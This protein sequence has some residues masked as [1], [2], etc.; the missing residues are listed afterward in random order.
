MKTKIKDWFDVMFLKESRTS[1]VDDDLSQTRGGSQCAHW[2]TLSFCSR[3]R[4]NR[5]FCESNSLCLRE[6]FVCV[7]RFELIFFSIFVFHFCCV[8]RFA[9]FTTLS[10]LGAVYVCMLAYLNLVI[11]CARA[12]NR[13]WEMSCEWCQRF[14]TG[15]WEIILPTLVE[16]MLWMVEM[17]RAIWWDKSYKI[18]LL[19]LVFI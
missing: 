18:I 2:S 8:S 4:E 16:W 13:S 15:E 19:F 17:G 5:S 11:L 12:L 9:L 7:T 3:T 10:S 6:L 1:A 14:N